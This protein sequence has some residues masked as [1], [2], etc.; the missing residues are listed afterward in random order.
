MEAK[1]WKKGKVGKKPEQTPDDGEIVLVREVIH[2]SR[3]AT[4]HSAV[5]SPSHSPPSP[6]SDLPYV[7]RKSNIVL[8]DS[9]GYKTIRVT[10]YDG[11]QRTFNAKKTAPS[12][13]T[14]SNRSL[15]SV[16]QKD[17]DFVASMNSLEKSNLDVDV[18]GTK[19]EP[20]L[21]RKDLVSGDSTDIIEN[22]AEIMQEYEDIRKKFDLWQL[23]QARNRY[24]SETRQLHM[25][26]M[27]QHDSLMK[28]LQQVAEASAPATKKK[29][30]IATYSFWD[31]N[32]PS[33][34][35]IQQNRS[36]N[37][38]SH[39]REELISRW[40]S[41]HSLSPTASTSSEETERSQCGSKK[42][43]DAIEHLIIPPP[44]S[45]SDSEAHNKQLSSRRI[46]TTLID[47][48]KSREEKERALQ[49]ILEEVNE[50]KRKEQELRRVASNWTSKK[51]EG[52]APPQAISNGGNIT[53]NVTT[54]LLR[55]K[56]QDH[57]LL[58]SQKVFDQ[59]ASPDD[60]NNPVQALVTSVGSPPS[61]KRGHGVKPV[62]KSPYSPKILHSNISLYE[63]R[64]SSQSFPSPR[65]I[66]IQKSGNL[67]KT[68][69]H[70]QQVESP[71]GSAKVV[72]T[73]VIS[74]N[75]LNSQAQFSTSVQIPPKLPLTT[76]STVSRENIEVPSPP[77]IPNA[78]SN[79]RKVKEAVKQSLGQKSA[80]SLL[81]QAHLSTLESKD[82]RGDVK[83]SELDGIASTGSKKPFHNHMNGQITSSMSKVL[84]E[85]FPFLKKVGAPVEKN[86]ITLG[87]V[88]DAFSESHD[89]NI[90]DF[91]PASEDH[92]LVIKE[93]TRATAVERPKHAQ[94]PTPPPPPP[95]TILSPQ[96]SLSPTVAATR[97]ATSLILTQ[98][99]ERQKTKLKPVPAIEK[100][101]ALMDVRDSLMAEIRNAG[102]LRALR[103]TSSQKN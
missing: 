33:R 80:S 62:G 16:F 88:L 65:E 36:H 76:R 8:N 50:L 51:Q 38:E 3:H 98:D 100:S 85:E 41:N 2:Y 24:S 86:G 96:S 69:Q 31:P 52:L 61:S 91:L 83:E 90:L 93:T 57:T 97:P 74:Q 81:L 19:V 21:L 11:T 72:G 75:A 28:K 39:D 15:H 68:S 23:L 5:L 10:Q 63:R 92:R 84:K 66:R 43:R 42:S 14:S 35:S 45:R 101:A 53:T 89:V 37:S 20:D 58:S 95:P 56:L 18:K 25:E 32:D 47:V 17:K 103:Q 59:Q 87:K 49:R 44:G 55:K 9:S 7:E 4:V 64:T 13:P 34:P 54:P 12:P 99:L 94:H 60:N 82:Q 46:E 1:I 77:M 22:A 48:N 79:I 30:S 26:L 6:D 67:E 29:P 78:D 70:P 27:R 73:F 40:A 102:G 71:N